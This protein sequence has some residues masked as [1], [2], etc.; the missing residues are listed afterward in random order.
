MASCTNSSQ[1]AIIKRGGLNA[2]TGLVL[3][4]INTITAFILNPILVGYFGAYFFGIWKSID[5]YLGFAS[6]ADG[7]GVQALKWTIAKDE[8]SEDE[9]QKKR[10]VGSAIIVWA[11]F[12]PILITII[13]TIAYLSPTLIS[14]IQESDQG[15]VLTIILLLGLNLIITPLLNISEAVLV[16]TNRGYLVNYI[17]IS[18]LIITFIVTYMVV[19][20]EFGLE[21][22]AISVVLITL[23][24][25]VT[26][27]IVAKKEVSWFATM[28]PTKAELKSFFKFSSWKLAWSFVAR[29]LMASEVIFLSILIGP[30]LVSSYIFTAYLV[31]TGISI[32]AIVTSSFNPGI[33]RM[34]GGGEYDAC[35]RVIGNLREAVLAFSIF[36]GAIILLLNQ[37]FIT[38][39]VGEEL[40]LGSS[41]NLLIVFILIQLLL[42]R[43]EAFLIDVSLTIKNKVLLGMSSIILSSLFAIVG[44]HYIHPSITTIFI[45]IFLGRL[46]ILF[47]FPIMVN[48][49]MKNEKKPTF[50]LKLSIYIMIILGVS[51]TIG[52]QQIFDSWW[53]LI[54]LGGLESLV[55]MG[56][57][58]LFLLRQENQVL[59]KDKFLNKIKKR[60]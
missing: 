30:S 38:L 33:G 17:R 3:F 5:K 47:I 54:L 34:Y 7:K 37:S 49:I 60:I 58:Y 25:G 6:I 40:F 14:N 13:V 44:Y 42:I 51:Y 46:P 21:E 20:L 48:K 41:A 45:G 28:K 29:F 39:W 55:L 57:V 43:N 23:L 56:A 36:I 53:T 4:F 24:R 12:L 50:S 26:Y 52:T 27:F 1:K 16:G 2:K 8:S 59:I 10:F 15:L 18:W 32:T 11:I 31:V 19:F 9:E 22:L 35:Q